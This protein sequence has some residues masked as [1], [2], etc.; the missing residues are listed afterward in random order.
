MKKYITH[1]LVILL[2]MASMHFGQPLTAT[3]MEDIE[4]FN[5]WANDL[6]R[7][8]DDPNYLTLHYRIRELYFSVEPH[9]AHAVVFLGDSITYGGDWSKL[10]PDLPVDNRGIGGDTTTGL[11]HRLDEVIAQKPAKI[12]LMIGTN[13]L[14]YGRSVPN[15]IANYRHI[16]E[17]FHSELPDTEIYIQSV[18][19]FNETIFPSNGLRSNS[20]IRQ[21]NGEL[22]SL[23][24]EFKYPFIDLSSSFTG[25]D[26]Q[27]PAQLTSD[28]L[29]LSNAGYLIWRT[30]IKGM[31]AAVTAVGNQL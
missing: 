17:R 10:F 22:R 29:H 8:P 1:V 18:L 12:F 25:P 20:N 11:L 31:V 9:P 26:G 3:A 24:Y 21:L 19:P 15:I 27:L 16:L 23:A 5:L 14:C 6:G 28:G 2:L 7:Q 4:R 30:R 13:D